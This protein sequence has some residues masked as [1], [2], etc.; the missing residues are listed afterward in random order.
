M[1]T[2]PTRATTTLLA[3]LLTTLAACSIAPGPPPVTRYFA[4]EPQVATPAADTAAVGPLILRQVT[5][6]THLG[7]RISWRASDV[8]YGYHEYLLWTEDPEEYVADA[9]ERLIFQGGRFTRARRSGAPTLTVHLQAFEAVHGADG[10]GVEFEVSAMLETSDGRILIDRR[11]GDRG[12]VADGDA[13]ELARALGRLMS[14]VLGE[15][16]DDA[17]AAVAGDA[18]PPGSAR[19]DAS[20]PPGAPSGS[21]GPRGEPRPGAG[22][23]QSRRAGGIPGAGSLPWRT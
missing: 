5:G 16:V 23:G 21:P 22:G 18:A 9:L 1:P 8:E 13:A 14:E 10:R 19:S 4:P 3:S 2:A 17:A 20:D 7:Q 12:D 15:L 6:S 11:Y